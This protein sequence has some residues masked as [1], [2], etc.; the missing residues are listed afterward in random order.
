MSKKRGGCL[1]TFLVIILVLALLIAGVVLIVGNLTPAQLGLGDK[2]I[3]SGTV[4]E[5]GI[6]DVKLLDLF[7][8]ARALTSE[9]TAD[10]FVKNAP[11]A[12][13][14]TRVDGIF[15]N[16]V[17]VGEFKYGSLMTS[18]AVF[19]LTVTEFKLKDSEL[20]YVCNQTLAE[21][22]ENKIAGALSEK[23]KLL[24]ELDVNICE[25]SLETAGNDVKMRTVLS[26]DISKYAE[27]ITLPFNMK[28]N[29]TLYIVVT[30]KLG[31]SSEGMIAFDLTFATVEIS[32]LNDGLSRELVDKIVNAWYSDEEITC[33]GISDESAD[34]LATICGNIGR[35]GEYTLN[36][37]NYGLN[38]I[39]MQRKINFVVYH[40]INL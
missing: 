20:A 25:I 10:A 14:K 32:G 36:G 40:T 26:V 1:G 2:N 8:I 3:G 37:N 30:H 17:S 18:N 16:T 34:L 19:S 38:G 23:I 28:V 7:R 33:K 21:V 27:N 11:S 35:I 5:M 24:A 39:D 4:A 31:V 29:N 22:K 6:G 13:D 15:A 12:E 9:H